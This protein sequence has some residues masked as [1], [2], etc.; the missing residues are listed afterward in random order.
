MS[1]K[2]QPMNLGYFDWYLRVQSLLTKNNPLERPKFNTKGPNQIQN[3]LA[4]FYSHTWN[5]RAKPHSTSQQSHNFETWGVEIWVLG[6]LPSLPHNLSQFSFWVTMGRSFRLVMFLWFFCTF[7]ISIL[8]LSCQS[9]ISLIFIIHLKFWAWF[10]TINTSKEPNGRFGSFSHFRPLL[11]K[12]L[13]HTL[14]T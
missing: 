6:N 14:T 12:R 8:I 13:Q 5:F 4:T 9:T 11:Q 7:V 10:S 3:E 2:H 1:R